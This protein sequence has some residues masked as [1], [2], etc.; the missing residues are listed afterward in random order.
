MR[1]IKNKLTSSKNSNNI[2]NRRGKSFGYQVLG[3]GAGGA[4]AGPYIADFVIIAGGGGGGGCGVHGNGGGAGG[5]GM[6]MSHCY[7]CA[8]GLEFNPGTPYA[9]TVGAGGTNVNNTCMTRGGS[10]SVVY[11]CGTRTATGGGIG[12]GGPSD[13]GQGPGGAGGATASAPNRLGNTPPVPAA[14]GGPQGGDGSP[15]NVG[16][17]G[18]GG[19][20]GANSP[21]QSPSGPGGAGTVTCI[22]GSP[23]QFSGGG[24]GGTYGGSAGAG[25]AGGGS[26]GGIKDNNCAAVNTG[27]GGGGFN[28]TGA[29][30]NQ[31]PVGK[32]GNGGSGKVYLRFPGAADISATPGTNTISTLP[33]PAGGCKLATFTVTG[34]VVLA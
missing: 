11:N 18:G 13:P 7:S 20:D 9:V 27:G 10:S 21:P 2:Q 30:G 1:D 33:A 16:G 22:T 28:P 29:P 23:L 25:G 8:A 24:G 31:P 12:H 34:A 6:L 32:G 3:F 4:A 26:P 17:G 14:N 19:K 15:G 5:G